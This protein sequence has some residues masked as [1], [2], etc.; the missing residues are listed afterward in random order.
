MWVGS[1][2]LIQFQVKFIG[3]RVTVATLVIIAPLEMKYLSL[4]RRLTRVYLKLSNLFKRSKCLKSKNVISTSDW[5]D[6]FFRL[7]LSKQWNEWPERRT[8]LL[9]CIT[10]LWCIFAHEICLNGGDKAGK[11][12]IRTLTLHDEEFKFSKSQN[13]IFGETF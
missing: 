12:P 10:S 4:S 2:Q 7:L 3:F 6:T 9:F 13:S 11:N 1:G 5:H 8:H